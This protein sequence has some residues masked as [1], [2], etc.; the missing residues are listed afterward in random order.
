MGAAYV[1]AAWLLIQVAETIFP[2]FGFDDTPAR[3]VVVVLAIGFIPS[4]ILAWAF[5]LTPEGLKKDKDVDRDRS[6]ALNT[7]KKLDRVIMVVLALALGYFAFDKFVL[8]PQREAAQRQ[9]QQIELQAAHQTGRSEALVESYGD[10]SI[11]VLPFADMSPEGDQAYFSDGITEEL[12]NVLAGLNELRVISRSSSF[13]L[14]DDG[15]SIPEVAEKLNVT[16]VLEGSVRKSDDQIRITAQLIEARSDAHLWSQTYDRKLDSIFQIQDEIA[17]AVVDGLKIT[18]LGAIPHPRETDPEVYSLYLQGKYL[19]TPPRQSK[20]DMEKSVSA[21]QQVLAIDPDYAPAWTGLS[22]NYEY[23]RRYHFLPEQ[24]AIELSREAAERALAIDDNLALAWSTLSYL[25]GKYDWDWEGAET[26]MNKALQ[27]EPNNT[28]VLLGTGSV[29]STLGQLDRSIELYERAVALDPLG[30]EGLGSLA[31]RYERRGRHDEALEICRRILVL[32]PE[33][34]WAHESIAET[35][36]RQGNP[37]R[38]LDELNKLPYSHRANSLKA[39]ALFILGEEEES[40]ALTSEFLST[41]AEFG[42]FAKAMIYAWRG[43]NDLAFKSLE[44]AFD[45]HNRALANILLFDASRHLE[46]DPRYPIF[47]EKLGLLAAWKAM[48]RD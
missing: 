31:R 25:R 22:W 5:E 15:L 48:P 3:I 39:E 10:K 38:A 7:G 35:Y 47:L 41:P 46:D 1:V 14:R 27:L 9:Q 36:L 37:E 23:Q 2:L 19:M 6:I 20:E 26:A 43:E 28:D 29:A 18:L 13:A 45:Q 34:T 12:L 11:A 42:P 16:Y 24:Q 33:N 40:L 17:A 21:F 8:T 44:F 4:L 32:F 30:L